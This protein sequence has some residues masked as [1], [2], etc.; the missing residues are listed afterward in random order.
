MPSFFVKNEAI[1]RGSKGGAIHE[2]VLVVSTQDLPLTLGK[3][4]KSF[5][6]LSVKSSDNAYLTVIWTRGV[7]ILNTGHKALTAAPGTHRRRVRK[8]M[9]AGQLVAGRGEDGASWGGGF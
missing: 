4:L 5:V 3:L 1:G 9:V 2:L 7:S 6:F 8:W